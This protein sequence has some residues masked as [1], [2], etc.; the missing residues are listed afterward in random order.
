MTFLLGQARDNIN[1]EVQQLKREILKVRR[2]IFPLRE[3]INRIEKGEHI[4]LLNE[5]LLIIEIFTII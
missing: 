1:I 4:N 3:I 5:Q 2:A